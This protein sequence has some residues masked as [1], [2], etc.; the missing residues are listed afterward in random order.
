VKGK[1]K[2]L[3]KVETVCPRCGLLCPI[4]VSI[5]D[6]NL[7][8]I[9]GA[10]EGERP[11]RGQLCV[12]GRFEPLKTMGKRLKTPLIKG[13][14]GEWT[15][16]T[17]VNALNTVV[18]ALKKAGSLGKDGVFGVAS[19]QCSN[20][21]LLLL[22]EVL[23][24]ALP[25]GHVD[26]MGGE[27]LRTI[28]HAWKELGRTF[29]GLKE[30]SWKR[31]AEADFILFAGADPQDSQPLLASLVRRGMIERGARV[32]VI[33][34]NDVMAPWSS[35]FLSVPE[36]R[37]P[38]AVNA[39]LGEVL[40]SIQKV[41][42]VTRWTRIQDEVGTANSADLI[43]RLKLTPEGRESFHGIARAFAGAKAPIVIAGGEV[44]GPGDAGA[45]RCLMYLA[46]LKGLLPNE[47]LRL[48]TLKPNGN[49]AGAIKL[50]IAPD[51]DRPAGGRWRAGILLM[52]DEEAP[53]A[54]LIGRLKGTEFLAVIAP[55]YM[56][57][58]AE[59]AS[60]LIPKPLWTEEDGTYT[61]LDGTEVAQ[62]T[63][64]IRPPAGV[65]ASW[66]TL[67]ALADGFGLR[68]DFAGWERVR[69]RVMAE[70]NISTPAK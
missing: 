44:T 12:K 58:L 35:F 20:E 42:P 59:K 48:V 63:R 22:R 10:L 69:D 24:N 26:V 21:E 4:V 25:G 62:C 28:S 34:S 39:L 13:K 40:S 19:G 33:G 56:D 37:L 53:D 11:D 54:D 18:G 7:V 55:Y 67:R 65:K 6:N 66:E 3:K 14:G 43:K 50:G 49:S 36:K 9:D 29:L 41:D 23:A 52:G 27:H 8:R 1:G 57:E 15:A 51:G 2:E 68:P 64:A 5:R 46:L 31:I 47:T 38:V 45:L 32:G 16:T 60:V 30:T 70:M 17:W 61:S